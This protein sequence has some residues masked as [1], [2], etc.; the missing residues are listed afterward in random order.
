MNLKR[1]CSK[2]ILLFG[3]AILSPAPSLAQLDPGVLNP[4][5]LQREYLPPVPNQPQLS[6][7]R[8]TPQVESAPLAP[9]P[10]AGIRIKIKSVVF[11][12]NTR[13]P[14]SELQKLASSIINKQVGFEDI[15][16]FTEQVTAYYRSKGYF[17]S[18]AILPKQDI[19]S[20]QLKIQIY[21]GYIEKIKIQPSADE[22]SSVEGPDTSKASLNGPL[23]TWLIRYLNP[24]V[25]QSGGP[26]TI[27]KL[28]RQL[29]LA[30]ANG[31]IKIASVLS[32]GTAV[33]S[34]LLTLRIIPNKLQASVGLDN[35]VPNQLG[36]IRGTVSAYDTPVVIMPI[37]MAASASYTWPIENGLSSLF[38]SATLP[39][40]ASGLTTSGSISYTQ[41][42]SS[43]LPTGIQGQNLST[44]GESYFGS[45]AFR[46]P[47]WLDRQK[48]AFLAAQL[49]ILN[50][51]NS[52]LV[53]SDAVSSTTADLRTFRLRLEA[54][55]VARSWSSQASVQFSQGLSIFGGK[56]TIDVLG[57]TS[58]PYYGD[59]DFS[60][61]QLN[62]GVT[63][64]IT[65]DSLLQISLRGMA[66]GAKGPTPSAE[67]IGFGGS[68]YGRG[69]RSLTVL[70]DQGILGSL[71]LSYGIPSLIKGLF[72]Q[73]YTFLDAGSVALKSR[74]QL[75][76]GA[77][78][79]ATSGVGLRLFSAASNWLS[80][81]TGC[82][83]PFSSN[84]I[85]AS[86]GWS[87]ANGYFRITLN[88]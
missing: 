69:Y 32:P 61:I 6:P 2:S 38:Y 37:G 5:V 55:K 11:V 76:N 65:S 77:Q 51:D 29:L 87:N 24:V 1:Y 12:G 10:D 79:V 17:I 9:T 26:L 71:E 56:N 83:V 23:E 30:E 14:D 81:D 47:L 36:N 73:P 85:A 43:D 18:V 78:N 21:E 27:R 41:T 82:G 33:G 40:G 68:N 58:K 4:G 63:R 66:Q 22:Q 86:T 62:L 70:G 28:E 7:D 80:I 19:S 31:G 57:D 64:N 39:I 75:V 15:E 50:S 67:Q 59:L 34:S 13:V 53:N 45:L 25:G 35:W 60:T 54:N 20:G 72:L 16:R 48:S 42:N 44:G 84:T 74:D 88:F 3:F 46:Y 8:P 49:D 52:T